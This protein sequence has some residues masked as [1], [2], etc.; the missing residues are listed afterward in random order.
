LFAFSSIDFS[1]FK[2][3]LCSSGW[4]PN[5]SKASCLRQ[6]AVREILYRRCH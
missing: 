5:S 6:P 2:G 3:T 1:T 4:I